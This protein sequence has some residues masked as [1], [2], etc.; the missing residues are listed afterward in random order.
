MFELK[1]LT[2]EGIGAALS[3]FER[4]RL[5]NEP[6]EAESICLDVLAVDPENQDATIGL[7]LSITDQF[8]ME[9]GA[10]VTRAREL[11]PRLASEYDRAYYAG[12]ICERRGKS[13]L[14]KGTPGIGP[15]VYDWIH[16]AMD[17]FEEAKKHRPPGN[18][19][20]LLRWNTCVRILMRHKDVRPAAEENVPT[21]LE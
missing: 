2:K 3:K 21:L 1:T 15:V 12:I 16:Q 18:E 10:N 11:L 4:Y 7:L 5:L 17:H 13:L 14:H 6:W 20:A 8:G 9:L 19:D